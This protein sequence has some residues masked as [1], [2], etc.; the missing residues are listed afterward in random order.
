[1]DKAQEQIQIINP[2]DRLL[3]R[4]IMLF[5]LKSLK[6]RFGF[7]SEDCILYLASKGVKVD[8]EIVQKA[9]IIMTAAGVLE[10]TYSS[11]CKKTVYHLH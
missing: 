2:E 7:D 11:D 5:A 8:A 3:Y 6:R 9:L 10:T 4:E 1:M